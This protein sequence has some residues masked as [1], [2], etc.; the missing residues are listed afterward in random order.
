[1]ISDYFVPKTVESRPPQPLLTSAI[2]GSSVQMD[3]G[4][5]TKMF[6]ET[7]LFIVNLTFEQLSNI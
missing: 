3:L 7:V 4:L 2:Y 1:M 5:D 6:Y